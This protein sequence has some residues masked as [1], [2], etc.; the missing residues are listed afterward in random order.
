[1]KILIAPSHLPEIEGVYTP[2]L[3]TIPNAELVYPHRAAQMTEAELLDQ[4]P[5]CVASLAGSEPYTERVIEKAA[6]AGLKIIARAGVGYDGV[7]VQAATRHG[8]VVT[9]APG[10]NH[11]AVGETALMLMLNLAKSFVLQHTQI[12]QGKW[13]RRAYQPL[14]GQTLGVIGLGRTGQATTLRARAFGMSVV[15][16]DPVQ[17]QVFAAANQVRFVGLEELLRTSDYVSLHVPLTSETRKMMRAET[18]SLLKPTS[19]LINCSRG[20]VV[21]ENALLEVLVNKRIAGAGLDVFEHEPPG[22]NPLTKLDNVVLTAH[23]AG[24]DWQSRNDMARV[25]AEAIAQLAHGQWPTEWVVNN[26]LRET[27]KLG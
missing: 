23:T 2:A 22:D 9:Y 18:L 10:T 17:N 7:D 27:W 1:M 21:D 8:I 4:L 25:P 6:K 15:A 20:E 19:Y 11:E 26:E 13:P 3:R 24:V 14:R 5:G 16:T 12:S